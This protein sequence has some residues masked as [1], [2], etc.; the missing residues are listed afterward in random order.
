MSSVIVVEGIHDEMRIKEIYPS[1]NV[2]TTNGREISETTLN[3]I[4]ELSK[5]NEIIIFTDPDTPGEKIRERIASI[6]PNAKH[7]FLRKKDAISK[8]HKKVGI[9]HA[10]KACISESL[11]LVY[12]N[13][14]KTYTIQIQDLYDLDLIGFE[15]SALKRE[16]ISNYL[17][18]GKPNAKTFL[19]RLNMLQIHKEE[20]VRLCQESEH[21]VL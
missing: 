8:N 12:N 21:Q 10:S 17:N 20:L 14:I 9:E 6:V 5:T 19:K 1:A 7:A 2:V 4:A 11:A 16:W 18:I 3:F 15:N 13:A